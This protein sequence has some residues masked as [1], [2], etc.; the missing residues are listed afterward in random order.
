MGI[1]ECSADVAALN[2]N[3]H[4]SL[5]DGSCV[6]AGCTLSQAPNYNPSATLNDESCIIPGCTFVSALNYNPLATD[7]YGSC[8][9]PGCAYEEAFNFNPTSNFDDG[10][11]LLTVPMPCGEGT[12]WDPEAGHCVLEVPM[13]LEVMGDAFGI[14]NPCYFDADQSG[15]IGIQDLFVF[16]TIYGERCP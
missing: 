10:S 9:F 3:P 7:D 14:A 6:V 8:E 2:F 1:D 13:Y 11:C 12:I 4:A 15:H 16:L 5:D